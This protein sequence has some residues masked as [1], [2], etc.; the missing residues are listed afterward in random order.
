MLVGMIALLMLALKVSGL[1]LNV[2]NNSYVVT[3]SFDNIGD[4]KLRAPI[5]L[6]GVKVG[7]VSGIRLDPQTYRADVTL[8]L[9]KGIEIPSDSSASILTEGLLGSN[10][11]SITPGYKDDRLKKGG[12]I[13]NTN[14][15][16]I[17][18]NLI[19]QLLFNINEEK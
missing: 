18:E 15:A 11:V 14:P 1:N 5:T 6:A 17:L 3:A 16:I 10:Y 8:A 4:L 12:K 19:G 2:S 9:E 13:D 7:Y